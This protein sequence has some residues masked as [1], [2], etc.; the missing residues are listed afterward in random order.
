M[1]HQM[2]LGWR[3]TFKHMNMILVL[4]LYQLLWGFLVYR[5][6]DDTVAPLLRR[7]PANAPTEQAVQSFLAEAQFQLFKTDLIQPYLWL[8]GGLFLARMLLTPLFNAGLFYSIHHQSSGGE[9]GTRILEGIRKFWKPVV[10]L[11]WIG[12]ALMIAPAWWLVPKWID[13]LR[14]DGASSSLL[15]EVAPGAAIWIAWVAIIHLLF[16]SMQ[17][18]SVS[19]DGILPSLWQSVRRFLSYAAISLI[20]WGIAALLGL[21]V[22]GVSMAWAGLFALIVHQGY[23]LIQTLLRVWTIATQY[24]HLRPES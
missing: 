2:L 15:G 4:F 16:L 24:R 17:F 7:F 14:H 22:G 6:I 12:R 1:K 18:G 9:G 23:P 19:G 13:A 20:M 21:L 11:Y 5:A 10:L 3:L 8:L